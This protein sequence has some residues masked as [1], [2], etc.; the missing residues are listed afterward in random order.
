[1]KILESRHRSIGHKVFDIRSTKFEG[2]DD[3]SIFE[4]AQEENAIF[5]TTD[6]DFFFFLVPKL[7]F[8][9]FSFP[10][11]TWE[12]KWARNSVSKRGRGDK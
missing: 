2:T 5:L 8:L 6:K 9:T 12:R 11:C 1:M 3:F 4:L 10:S 7:Y